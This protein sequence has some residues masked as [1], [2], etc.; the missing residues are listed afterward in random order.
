MDYLGLS[1]SILYLVIPGYIRLSRA[2]LAYLRLS[3]PI[4]GYLWLYPAFSGN[5][6]YL[7]LAWAISVLFGAISYYLG[8][9]MTISVYLCL[10]QSILVYLGLSRSIIVNFGL[11]LAI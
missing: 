10:S 5:L 2:A 3:D 6:S 4:A 7:G 9:S 8:L 1:L 11:S